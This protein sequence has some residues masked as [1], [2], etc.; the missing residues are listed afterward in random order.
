M[1][2]L[3][4]PLKR[5]HCL[6]HLAALAAGGLPVVRASAAEPQDRPPLAF[7]GFELLDEQPD[8]LRAEEHRARLDKIGRQMAEGL[9]ARGLY[10]VVDLA[11]AEQALARARSENEFLYRCNAC[12]GGV[13][14]AWTCAWSAP[15]GS[16]GWATSSS[17]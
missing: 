9:E 7:L 8:P 5:R 16:S 11:P 10:R 2:T 14:E 3:P 6:L 13:G 1:I 17:T 12:L 4:R 15:A